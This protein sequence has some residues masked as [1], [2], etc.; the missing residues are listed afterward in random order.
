MRQMNITFFLNQNF[1]GLIDYLFLKD[2]TLI[3]VGEG[4]G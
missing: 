2:L 1:M 4:M 3:W